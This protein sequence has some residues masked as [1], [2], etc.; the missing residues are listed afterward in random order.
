M[1][2][3][4][5]DNQCHHSILNGHSNGERTTNLTT[6]RHIS[7]KAY[8]NIYHN[9]TLDLT[10]QHLSLRAFFHGLICKLTKAHKNLIHTME[11]TS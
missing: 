7:Y 9:W 11:P 8:H 5:G 2:R 10:E 3:E 4:L 1:C 6:P